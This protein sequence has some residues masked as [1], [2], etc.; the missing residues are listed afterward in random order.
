MAPRPSP[1]FNAAHSPVAP[2]PPEPRPPQQGLRLLR[3][4][5]RLVYSTCSIAPAENDGVVARALAKASALGARAVAPALRWPELLWGEG[6]DGGAAAAAAGC[7][8]TQHGLIA[9]PDRAGCGP[10]YWAVLEVP[11]ARRAQSCE[12][13]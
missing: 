13:G 9:L 1:L 2:T 3:P 12:G 11:A 4:G 8:A 10:I 7:E 5:G 6:R